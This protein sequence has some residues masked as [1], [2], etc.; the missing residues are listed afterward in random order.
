MKSKGCEHSLFELLSEDEAA[1]DECVRLIQTTT[2]EGMKVAR[3]GGSMHVAVF[4]LCCLL[5]S[6]LAPVLNHHNCR[7]KPRLPLHALPQP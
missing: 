6:A 7:R 2:E 3:N 5:P 1:S 4:R